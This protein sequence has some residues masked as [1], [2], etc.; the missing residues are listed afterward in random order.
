[1]KLIVSEFLTLDGVMQGPGGADEDREGGFEHGGWQGP[2]FDDAEEGKAIDATMN[3][4]GAFLLGRRT[5]DIF[6]AYW[7]TSTGEFADVMND[8]PTFVAST[9]LSEP[10]EWKNSTLLKGD[11]AEAVRELKEGDGKAIQVIGSGEL[12]RTLMANDLVDE[13]RL[14]VYPVVLGAGK[15]LFREGGPR[16]ALKLV[17]GSITPKGVQILTYRP[18]REE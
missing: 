17:D 15:R 3:E 18:E 1:M 9:T 2:Y 14:M 6:A 5:Y 4:T 12:A 10:L 7:P 11:V 16:I 8:M 13:Y